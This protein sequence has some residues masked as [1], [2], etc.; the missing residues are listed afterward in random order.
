MQ[1][2]PVAALGTLSVGQFLSSIEK[3]SFYRA[4]LT[5]TQGQDTGPGLDSFSSRDLLQPV[6]SA[7]CVER[8]R[9]STPTRNP[10]ILQLLSSLLAASVRIP[11]TLLTALVISGPSTLVTQTIAG[12]NR[13][14]DA[15]LRRTLFISD[16]DALKGLRMFNNAR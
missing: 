5:D 3:I 8:T 11:S 2:T 6:R 13:G 7:F 4:T 12:V 9:I 14:M 15:K 16:N 10:G 1:L